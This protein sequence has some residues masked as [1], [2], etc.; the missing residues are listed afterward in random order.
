MKQRKRAKSTKTDRSKLARAISERDQ[1]LEF[2][3][4]TGQILDSIRSSATDARPVFEAIARNVRSLLDTRY[5]VVLLLRGDSLELAAVH[6]DAEFARKVG[7][8]YGQ[9]RDSFPQP[10]DYSGVTGL[11]LLS[12]EVTQLAPI[13]G[14]P[15]A[16]ARAIA[17]AKG[18]GY[19]AMVVAPLVRDGKAIG[20][21][22]TVRLGPTR[23]SEKELRLLKT[24]ADQAVI[25]I[26]NARLFNETKEALERQTA[27]ANI[28]EVISSSPTNVQ[29][30]LDAVATSAARLCEADDALIQ[31]REGDS[32]R[33]VAQHGT[34]PT[35]QSFFEARPLNPGRVTDRA[36]L[37]GRHF[38][39]A[40]LQAEAKQFPEGSAQ[41]KE[42]GIRTLLV[43]PLMR[44]GSAIG[45]ILMRR[46]EKRPFSEQQIELVKTFADQA[47]IAIEN[48]RLFNETKE[49]LERQRASADILRVI[50]TSPSDVKPVLDE[51]AE[52][53]ARLCGAADVVIR[54]VDGDQMRLAAHF[55]SMPV[56]V[57][58][59]PISR[60]SVTGRS[61][62]DR[63]TIQ[64]DDIATADSQS[65]Y[66]EAPAL[67]HDVKFHTMLAVPLVRDG[68]AIGTI[69]LRRLEVR[70]FSDHQVALL[71]SFANQAVIAIENVRLFNE[72]KEALEQ[73]TATA[74]I[75]RV[76]S[77]TPTDVQPVFDAIARSALRIFG[78][79]DVS[80]GLVSGDQIEIRS[81]TLHHTDKGVARRI[82]LNRD[83]IVGC[84]MLDRSGYNIGDSEEPDTPP[85]T[86]ERARATGWR[87]VAIAPM[88]RDEIAIGHIGVH[89][90]EAVP[91]TSK[92]FALLKTFADQA[93]IAIENVRLFNEIQEKSAQLEIA[94]RHKSEFLANMSHELRTP[95]NAVIGFSE[96]L[97]ERMFGEINE[98]QADYLKDIHESGKH[99]LSL[100]ND[101]LDLSKIEAGR[102]ELE[103][104]TFHLPTAISN[105]MTLV[106]ERAQRC[107]VALGAEVDPRLGEFQAD[108]RKVKQILL[109]L[110]SNAVKFTPEGGKV[111]VSAKLNADKIEI[112]VKDTGVGI[113]AEDQAKLFEEFRQVGKDS[114]RK[115]EGTGLGLALTKKFVELHGGAIHVESEPG[116]GSTF[117]FSLPMRA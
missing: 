117:M 47:V 1:A 49:A 90:A 64:V 60:A 76:I 72:T 24:F 100:I 93:A 95:L 106:R 43:V 54:R 50:A 20:S 34:L 62:L 92:Q 58:V 98:K 19:D 9:F 99:L 75:L 66:S 46:K 17:L 71:E 18:F 51:M 45:A 6:G 52:T 74:E 109:N 35:L 113:S 16:S 4:A 7:G 67:K 85:L 10:V 25:A 5:A 82:P 78:G 83:S 87:S 94:N 23:F 104:G 108:E 88:L 8:S 12:G 65:E 73:Q 96:V 84:A 91:L 36:V 13:I 28:L 114:A 31:L 70:R 57:H 48:A 55:G 79:M 101:I 3:R 21:I 42:V 22:G 33:Y 89:R 59:Q 80:V 61:V 103:V 40:D 39:I 38:H 77:S 11:A 63:R 14:N 29:P 107:G 105:A 97:S 102:M 37:E 115:A 86:R 27:T 81:S 30:V 53:A 69:L 116:K 110:L 15:H 68:A 112:A 2:Q 56:T 111:N 26:E 41:A 44:E 32:V